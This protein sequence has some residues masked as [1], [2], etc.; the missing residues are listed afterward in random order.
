V[1][2]SGRR[3]IKLPA[4]RRLAAAPPSIMVTHCP[5]PT[6]SAGASR[7]RTVVMPAVVVMAAMRTPGPAATQCPTSWRNPAVSNPPRACRKSATEARW[8][9]TSQTVRTSRPLAKRE[10]GRKTRSRAASTRQVA[11]RS[12]TEKIRSLMTRASAG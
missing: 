7:I 9:L 4:T 6:F 2:N 5:D 12:G 8:G 3:A 1:P 11:V 10:K